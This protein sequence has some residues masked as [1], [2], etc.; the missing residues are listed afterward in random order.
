MKKA[1]AMDA[2]DIKSMKL[3]GQVE[4]IYNDLKAAGFGDD[5]P[6]TV[7]DLTPFDQYHYFGTRAVD[8]AVERLGIGADSRVLEIG[9][10]IGGPSRHLAWRAGCRITALELQPDLDEVARALTGRCGLSDQVEHACGDVLTHPLPAE[11][12]DAVVSWLAL[13]HVPDQAALFARCAGALKP[14]GTLYAEDLYERA[15]LTPEEQ[16]RIAH[17]LYGAGLATRDDY[18]ATL[19]DAG[20]EDIAFED[21]SE[22][23]GAHVAERLEQY[24]AGFER[25]VAVHGGEVVAALDHFYDM[26]TTMFA[27]G[28]LGGVRVVARKR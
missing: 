25:H 19:D 1:R 24:R 18:C 28:R 20:F 9:S 23:W 2:P 5:D 3:Y 22:L 10:G 16:G 15:A 27:G 12:Y 17:E 7:A 21:M 14:G 11:P 6:L 13:Y 8:D 4:R 26:V